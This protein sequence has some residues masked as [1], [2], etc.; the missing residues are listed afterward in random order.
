M[1]S[2]GEKAVTTTPGSTMDQV[3]PTEANRKP[4]LRWT[5]VIQLLSLLWIAP[6]VALL[7]LN[8]SNYV[9]GGGL[10]C[11]VATCGIDLFDSDD[12]RRRQME[13][14]NILGSFQVVAK[15]LEVW[16][17][18]VMGIFVY[19]LT[20]CLARTGAGLPIFYLGAHLD[21]S[22]NLLADKSFWVSA[23]SPKGVNNT[24]GGRK[25]V[26]L[27]F[28]F[29]V[30]VVVAV[31]ALIGPATAVLLIPT[32]GWTKSQLNPPTMLADL[33]S[34][35]ASPA[36][37]ALDACAGL[38]PAESN[39]ACDRYGATL[40]ILFRNAQVN[41][42]T[43]PL[44][45]DALLYT[46]NRSQGGMF[47][48]SPTQQAL[49]DASSD[50]LKWQ[51]S[52][53]QPYGG[54]T[55]FS[56]YNYNLMRNAQRT[57]ITRIAPAF[58]TQ[59]TCYSN[60]SSVVRVA[61][62]MDV[63]CYNIPNPDDVYDSYTLVDGSLAPYPI[64]NELENFSTKCIRTGPG[65]PEMNSHSRFSLG[66]D[67]SSSVLDIDVYSSD[68]AVFLNTTTYP[69]SISENRASCDW[70]A[71]FAEA[72]DPLL[73]NLSV[74]P[75]VT[76]YS[77]SGYRTAN[78]LTTTF[79]RFATYF[80]DT[81]PETNPFSLVSLQDPLLDQGIPSSADPVF[82]HPDWTL[83]AWLAEKNRTMPA[84]RNRAEAMVSLF[85]NIIPAGELTIA[86]LGNFHN[87]AAAHSR[88]FIPYI[89]SI[90]SP[91]SPSSDTSPVLDSFISV[92]TW[93]Y[94][95]ESRTSKLGTVVAIIGC[96]LVLLKAIFGI[97][98]RAPR[99][100]FLN[101][102]IGALKQLPP[103]ITQS[104]SD[105]SEVDVGKQKVHIHN[106]EWPRYEFGGEV[107]Q[108]RPEG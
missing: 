16:F 74:N 63:R 43:N 49:Y 89:T 72:P 87:L 47:M 29:F 90:I 103:P 57:H 107:L 96:T 28:I 38:D 98:A 37:F 19:D 48:Y 80:L 97:I 50:Q 26:V 67:N 62:N 32:L 33:S 83:I 30:A 2:A 93:S 5:F 4:R 60:G 12:S 55:E 11:A 54:V 91:S 9:V 70:D 31:S 25:R 22:P 42:G 92:Y 14:R 10:N 76:E 35:D 95:L 65:W 46:F 21:L 27:P 102:V 86:R 36:S 45:T 77:M 39:F 104:F 69:C 51:Y 99:H 105:L 1:A 100:S 106:S 66:T 17:A 61:D 20:M 58:Y 79:L 15:A 8:L 94:G 56:L 59:S 40:D 3:T 78:C 84:Q 64:S 71:L 75:Q 24:S 23:Y 7:V 88:Y 34:A 108:L 53:S 85:R 18:T 81:T 82:V 68:R 44:M 73:R 52:T 101:F 13:D 41:P 6:I